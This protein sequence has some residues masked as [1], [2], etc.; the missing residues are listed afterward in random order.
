MVEG[1]HNM[2]D[3]IKGCSFSNHWHGYC[4]LLKPTSD[5]TNSKSPLY[6]LVDF[7]IF[8]PLS[9]FNMPVQSEI[10]LCRVQLFFLQS[11]HSLYTAALLVPT[12]MCDARHV[13]RTPC[14]LAGLSNVRHT[15]PHR[16][17]NGSYRTVS[18]GAKHK[19]HIT[20]FH[21]LMF[22][23]FLAQKYEC[24]IPNNYKTDPPFTFF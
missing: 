16:V 15:W 5:L 13:W 12:T 19:L 24:S 14:G 20:I 17:I 9:Y 8:I 6:G 23:F 11:C 1:H 22:N 4:F 21:F 2:R 7:H 10:S 18:T 3:F